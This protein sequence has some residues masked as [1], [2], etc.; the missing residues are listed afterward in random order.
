MG[1][2]SDFWNRF[3]STGD[4][5]ELSS[6]ALR[7]L[8]DMVGYR[9]QETGLLVKALKH[10]SYV[11]AQQ[12]SGIESNERL[13]FLGDAVLDLIVAE[14]LFRG[15]EDKREGDLTQMKSLLVSRTVLARQARRFG[16]DA[17]VL[18]SAEERDSGGGR[19]PSILCDAFESLIG[20]IYLDGGIAPCRDF[21]Q[22]AV[23]DDFHDLIKQDDY[24]NFKSKLL[25]H[26]QSLGNGHPRYLVHSEE[27]PDHDKIFRVE[28]S[29][30]GERI[31]RGQ[32]RSKKEAQQMAAKD[33]LQYL[34]AL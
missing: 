20:A 2:L 5:V 13:E 17:F 7:T 24:V 34:E 14:F 4:P 31:G 6:E 1:W 28:V 12:G 29:I 15:F 22:R 27:G 16:L 30:T 18:L 26:S 3:K 33:A 9:F 23:L 19:Q 21:V 25:E 32:G 10:R 11:Y 8:E